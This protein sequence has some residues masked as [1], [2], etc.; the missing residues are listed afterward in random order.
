M[1]KMQPT[2]IDACATFDD[3]LAQRLGAS[4]AAGHPSRADR[5]DV[6]R[7][8]PDVAVRPVVHVTPP[9]L[10]R[11]R[12]MTGRAMTAEIIQSTGDDRLEYRYRAS[13]D[14][15]VAY[16]RGARREG[17]SVIEGAPRSTLRDFARKL[18]LVPA[19][20]DYFEWHQ[21]RTPTRVMFLYIDPP[22]RQLRSSPNASATRVGPCVFF[23]N[24]GVW[25]TVLKLK[26]LV[27]SPLTENC[28]YFE[29]LGAVLFEELARLHRGGEGA[30]PSVRGGLAAWQQRI[31]TA[32]I[33]AHLA[34]QVPLAT[35]AQLARLSPY[36]FARAF[37]QS[38]GI[39][40]H[41]YHTWR[42]IER[43]KALLEDRTVT[44]TDVG[45]ALGFSETSSFTAAFRKTTG[46][47]PSRYHRMVA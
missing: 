42:R 30:G 39:P 27:E 40:P 43:A 46:L 25:S 38:F 5:Q 41:R 32:Y 31:V 24:D 47:T 1:L 45:L 3:G 33:E 17:E 23:E 26:R 14:L 9:G 10:V 28:A 34:E 2:E 7:A 16:E 35:L 20:H 15:L 36:H 19:G 18:T 44:V 13:S 8:L 37:K 29:A 6:G 11:R 4:P 21:P 22:E 12:T